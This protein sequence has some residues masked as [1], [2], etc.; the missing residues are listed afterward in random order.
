MLPVHVGIGESGFSMSSANAEATAVAMPTPSKLDPFGAVLS[1][2]VPGLGQIVQ[3]RLS[4]GV[5]FF[6]G[7]Y[8]LFFYGQFLGQGHN[9]YLGDSAPKVLAGNVPRLFV[10]LWNAKQ[11]AG[12]FWVG[13]AAWPAIYHYWHDA[14]VES[15]EH[16]AIVAQL[17]NLTWLQR[18]QIALPEERLNELQRDGDK[19][20]DLGWVYTVI[21]GVLN[22]LV[23]FDALAGP[24]FIPDSEAKGKPA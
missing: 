13:I 15:E 17:D 19:R 11:F 24:A 23:I 5:V 6:L 1:Y 9:V 18:T 7:V 8:G 12:Q 21:A 4:K 14:P 2:L 16:K 22:V 3:G 20:W 10:N